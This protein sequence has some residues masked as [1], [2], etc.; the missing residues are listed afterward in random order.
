MVKH[1]LSADFVFPL[2]VWE[3]A[4]MTISSRGVMDTSQS[5]GVKL[6]CVGIADV[7]LTHGFWADWFKV[8]R[9]NMIPNM[10]EIIRDNNTSHIY[11]NFLVAAGLLDGRHRGA[12]WQDGDFYKWMEAAAYV[13]GV[14]KD[15]RL[16][17]W[18]D[19]AIELL[20]KVQ[21]ADGYI[22]TP[23]IIKDRKNPGEA[24]PFQDRFDFEMYNMGH[25]MTAA[26]VHFRATGKTGMLDIAR[27][28]ADYLYNWFGN[29]DIEKARNCVCPAHYMGIIEMWR[30]TRDPRYLALA[31]TFMKM[32]EMVE[33]GG[34]DNQDRIPFSTQTQ[35]VGHAVRANYLYAGAADI[36][37]ET[38]D[39][40]SLDN[41]KE[42]WD[43]I[44][45][46][47][48]YVTGACGALYDGASPDG[49]KDQKNITRVHQAYGRKYQLPNTT[50]HNETCAN[51][52]NAMFNWRMLDITGEGRYADIAELVMYNGALAGVSLDGKS[53]FYTNTLR[54]LDTLPFELRWS[55]VRTPYI[56]CFCCP[57]NIVRT[58]AEAGNYIYRVS[59]EG[60]WVNLYAGSDLD[61]RLPDGSRVKLSQKTNY[62]WDGRITI[63]VKLAEKAD[64]SLMLRIPGWA[65]GAKLKV[66][67]QDAAG[68]LKAGEYFR[69]KRQWSAGDVV[70]LEL[71][72]EAKLIE[73]NPFVE[74]T[75]N[76]VAVKRGP[77]VYCLE[78]MDLPECVKVPQVVLSAGM[79]LRAKFMK[80]LL[81]GVTVLE[82]KAEVVREPDWQGELYREL[83]PLKKEKVN[84]RLVPY[85]AWCNR[86]KGEMTVWLPLA[87]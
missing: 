77:L 65:K 75:R 66:N 12:G 59:D 1:R 26:C 24:K 67:G 10:W 51:I 86:G 39:G 61:T 7:K 32:R 33:G 78:S 19:E 6:K 87:R 68:E 9:E 35:A 5:P 56:N 4:D 58:V 31:A 49:A 11:E 71:P 83:P 16:A 29:P 14:T 81:G 44:T 79:R 15:T 40:V 21:R 48:M 50:A 30:T 53:F 45:D 85:Y 2:C 23:V 57:P 42:I 43:S 47:K 73:A 76:Q 36:Y 80:D 84:I 63:K 54:Q 28:A 18:M 74:E 70:K 3:L 52:G 8:C 34:D 41:L 22:H 72:M 62:P 55:R 37:S 38:G 20:A 25:L 13:Y 27:K 69:L 60:V 64:M 46:T 82:G 17:A